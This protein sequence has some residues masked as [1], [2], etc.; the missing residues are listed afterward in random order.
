[1]ALLD[2]KNLHIF[3]KILPRAP[4]VAVLP[5]SGEPWL[6]LLTIPP[7]AESVSLFSGILCFSIEESL[8]LV[9]GRY[10][11]L[12]GLSEGVKE[13]AGVSKIVMF[14][15]TYPPIS[16]GLSVPVSSGFPTSVS[17]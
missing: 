13:E 3:L 15:S 6:P 5:Q 8:T 11:W 4:G 7:T 12:P 1:M 16:L 14:T 10:D 9:G 2:M 17:P